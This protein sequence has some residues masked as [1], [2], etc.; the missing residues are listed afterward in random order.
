MHPD[1]WESHQKWLSFFLAITSYQLPVTSYS[2]P[3]TNYQ[4]R[5]LGFKRVFWMFTSMSDQPAPT[6]YQLPRQLTPKL[7]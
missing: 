6:N 3:T 4:Q 2:L 7:I 5:Y 1:D